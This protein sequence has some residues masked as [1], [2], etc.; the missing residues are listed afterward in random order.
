MFRKKPDNNQPSP[1]RLSEFNFINS[2]DIYMDSACQSFRPQP[3]IDAINT[4][5]KPTT[6]VAVELNINGDEWLMNKSKQPEN[7]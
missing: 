5:T 3:V 7:Q 6:L 2:E 4:T 1:D